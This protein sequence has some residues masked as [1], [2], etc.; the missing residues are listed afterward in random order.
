MKNKFKALWEVI[1]S[2]VVFL[3]VIAIVCIIAISIPLLIYY[4]FGDTA[5]K[6]LS[7]LGVLLV[8]LLIIL[9]VV[10]FFKNAIDD[11]KCRVRFLNKNDKD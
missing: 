7:L 6:V 2:R 1:L 8:V 3:L 4:L 10:E 11:Y 5:F 9:Y